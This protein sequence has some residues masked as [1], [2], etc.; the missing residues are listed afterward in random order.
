[1]T[2]LIVQIGIF[3]VF[4]ALVGFILGWLLRGLRAAD[5]D[6]S[7]P[8]VELHEPEAQPS[9]PFGDPPVWP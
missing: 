2:Y 4:A 3:L 7:E 5:S 8:R 6:A 9:D 1:M